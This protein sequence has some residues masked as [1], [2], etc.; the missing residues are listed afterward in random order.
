MNLSC[1]LYI[2]LNLILHCLHGG[3]CRSCHSTQ[4]LSNS[5]AAVCF[6]CVLKVV[7]H[8]TLWRIHSWSIFE[9]SSIKLH[10][11]D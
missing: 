5:G 7:Q 6:S 11:A 9:E 10:R 3:Q 8:T 1:S 2:R 4:H